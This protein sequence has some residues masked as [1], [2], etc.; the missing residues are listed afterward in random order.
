MSQKKVLVIGADGQLGTTLQEVTS[1]YSQLDFT[2]STIQT[3]DITDKK[4]VD[5]LLREG[6]FDYCINCSAYTQVDMAET[7]QEL[8]DKINY[9][10][11]K[12]LTDACNE[13]NTCLIHIS[14]DYVFAGDKNIPIKESDITNPVNQYGKSKLKGE[15]YIVEYCKEYLIIRTSWLYSHVGNNFVKTMLKLSNDRKELK[16]IVD[17][18][19][20][21]TYAK[22]L[23]VTI[24][25]IISSGKIISGIYHFSNE[26]VTS[27]YDFAS[28]IFREK[29]IDINVY[30]ILTHEYPVTAKRPIYSVM[31]KSKIKTT[32]D[33]SIRHW[34]DALNECLNKL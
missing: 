16:V 11:V 3:L 25:N 30:P 26:G 17:Q 28:T 9:T 34:N 6:T 4:G 33:L 14:T 15:E 24:L 22:D 2:N 31:D 7:Q 18:V 29:K 27:W 13:T 8:A 23:A 12:N 32:Y 21:P 1:G 20:S 10:G 5:Q 19:G